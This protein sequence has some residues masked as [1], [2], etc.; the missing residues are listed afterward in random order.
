MGPQN[1]SK[2]A[3]NFSL[4]SGRFWGPKWSPKCSQIYPESLPR[5]SWSTPPAA[6]YFR[7]RFSWFVEPLGPLKIMLPCRREH[8]FQ[9][10]C[11]S[12]CGSKKDP[13][14]SPKSTPKAPQRPPE[15][16]KI[17]LKS[18][19]VFPSKSGFNFGQ[20]GLQNGS[21][22]GAQNRSKIDVAAGWPP[23]GRPE[24]SREPFWSHFGS[25]LDPPRPQN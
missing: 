14:M 23:K 3:S 20:F 9:K 8:V 25:I 4:L 15:E 7:T 17:R 16:I 24:A 11:F 1:H 6:H 10:I 18:L 21:Q 2:F 5:R 12:G 13:K 22:I 19:Q